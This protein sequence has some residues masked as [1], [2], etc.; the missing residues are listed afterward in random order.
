MSSSQ[1]ES[2]SNVGLPTY[3]QMLLSFG[4]VPKWHNFLSTLFI[5]MITTGF[6]IIPS[7][8]VGFSSEEVTVGDQTQ[9]VPVVVLELSVSLYV[10][11]H[12]IAFFTFVFGVDV[13]QPPG[14]RSASR[15]S[16]SA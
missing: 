8:L 10:Q 13:E 5:W 14:S 2:S 3:V 11:F 6:I 9:F 16:L 7:S 15:W 12:F 1:S 4:T